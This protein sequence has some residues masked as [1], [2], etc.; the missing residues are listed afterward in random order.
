MALRLRIVSDH[1]RA[2]GS[3][4][5]V[6]FGVTGGSIGRSHDNDW[7]LPDP[8]R[9]VSGRHAKILFRSGSF[10]LEDTS[11]N[12]TFVNDASHPIPRQNPYELRNGD[13]IRLG[14]YH[15]VVALD[16][17]NDFTIERT[18][19]NAQQ[20]ANGAGSTSARHRSPPQVQNHL[21]ASLNA[22]ALFAP[23][24]G[25]DIFMAPDLPTS[26]PPSVPLEDSNLI[27]ARRLE[28]LAHAGREQV[29]SGAA[30]AGIDAFARG[31]GL[32]V[33]KLAPG[34]EVAML[35]L[36]GRLLREALV[37]LKDLD[38]KQAEARGQFALPSTR[39]A[40]NEPFRLGAASDD[41][42]TQMLVSFDSRRIDAA[43]WLRQCFDQLRRH[44]E[45]MSAAARV[46]F[47]DF[48]HQL[49]PEELEARFDRTPKR[50]LLS[51]RP[52]NWDMYAEF[53]RTVADVPDDGGVPHTYAESFANAYQAVVKAEK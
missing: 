47:L 8:S 7:V 41:L 42:L 15:V 31:A 18:A 9:F 49:D 51:S 16:N 35:Q 17:S 52:N 24:G 25:S 14:E 37:G 3:R 44:H 38:T 43:Q 45:G 53:F 13:I 23:P 2:L 29:F 4:G 40:E 22:N 36:A 30:R 10:Y 6:V 46:G 32:D 34:A 11:T 39:S 48:L 26:E 5:A 21:D 1:R 20:R 28:R 33:A 19:A 27:A 12:G 50:S